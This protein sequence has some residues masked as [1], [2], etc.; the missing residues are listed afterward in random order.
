M[1]R[2]RGPRSPDGPSDGE[3]RL[4][5]SLVGLSRAVLRIQRAAAAESGLSMSKFFVLQ[6]LEGAGP[7]PTTDWAER[8]GASPSSVTELIDGLVRAGFVVRR[9]DPTDRR[10]VLV[11][12]TP[13]GRVAVRGARIRGTKALARALS[14]G[15]PPLDVPDAIA[16]VESLDLR[17]AAALHRAR[18]PGL[19]VHPHLHPHPP[20]TGEARPVRTRRPS[21]PEAPHG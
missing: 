11:A 5:R 10:K 19:H 12:L 13:A 4:A 21:P 1:T 15:P 2:R 9:S 14:E 6:G 20:G 7:T 3:E 18:G 8:M 16:A 17:I